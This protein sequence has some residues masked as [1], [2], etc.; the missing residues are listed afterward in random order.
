MKQIVIK[1]L[2]DPITIREE[3]LS[4][5]KLECR[6]YWNPEKGEIVIDSTLDEIDKH[7]VLIHEFMHL[8]DDILIQNGIRKKRSSHDLIL[9]MAD[10]LLVL[11]VASGVIEKFTM[12]DVFEFQK[13]M[14]DDWKE[15][16][17]GAG[18]LVATEK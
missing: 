10:N 17:E 1:T 12:K 4:N 8:I 3:D 5:H 13:R 9:H 15:G 18:I 14:T 6:G 16:D 2:G 7:A 11:L